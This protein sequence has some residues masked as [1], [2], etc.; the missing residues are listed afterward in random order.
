[1]TDLLKTRS[2]LCLWPED[3]D[4]GMTMRGAARKDYAKKQIKYDRICHRGVVV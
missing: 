1:M 3:L 2:G 4:S